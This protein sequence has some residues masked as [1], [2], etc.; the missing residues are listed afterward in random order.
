PDEPLQELLV[1]QLV[2]SFT[3]QASGQALEQDGQVFFGHGGPRTGHL[4]LLNSSAASPNNPPA[5]WCQGRGTVP[6]FSG[7]SE[8]RETNSGACHTGLPPARY[9]FLSSALRL[10]WSAESAQNQSSPAPPVS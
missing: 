1:G 3:R 2:E 7:R 4:A 5:F 6:F 9:L 8:K 10:A